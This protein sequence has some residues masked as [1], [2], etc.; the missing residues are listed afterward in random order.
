M[1]QRQL[2]LVRDTRT[3]APRDHRESNGG[4]GT[5]SAKWTSPHPL[6]RFLDLSEIAR[7]RK[8]VP[9]RVTD[10]RQLLGLGTGDIV[11]VD[12]SAIHLSK[13]PD[14]FFAVRES[15]GSVSI[16]KGSE[17]SKVDLSFGCRVVGRVIIALTGGKSL[18]YVPKI[19]LIASQ[20]ER[21]CPF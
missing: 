6:V 16:I 8:A 10:D 12:R 11:L 5:R 2:E 19:R 17:C 4:G 3:S 7:A 20:K 15:H 14:A 9:F 21:K 1:L 18:R 13:E